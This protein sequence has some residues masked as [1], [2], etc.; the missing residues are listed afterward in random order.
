MPT[1]NLI[2]GD[3]DISDCG[4]HVCDEK[5]YAIIISESKQ[6]ELSQEDYDRIFPIVEDQRIRR[7]VES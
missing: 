6:I 5:G 2:A 3:Y 4:C 1:L 7:G